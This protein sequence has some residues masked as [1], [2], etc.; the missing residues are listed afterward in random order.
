MYKGSVTWRFA[1]GTGDT[2]FVPLYEVLKRRGVKF[3]FFH[4]VTQLVCPP[5]GPQEVSEI[6]F[7]RQ[8]KLNRANYEPLTAPLRPAPALNF[9]ALLAWICTVAPVCGLRPI[10]ALR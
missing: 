3:E 9:G 6:H 5:T 10:R 1:A 7:N 8:A 2:V 4:E